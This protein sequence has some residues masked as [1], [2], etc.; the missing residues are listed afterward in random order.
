VVNTYG[1]LSYT[2]KLKF[3]GKETFQYT[4][5]YQTGVQSSLATATVNV[6]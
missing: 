6:K 1:T 5:R 3:R 4:V 2:P